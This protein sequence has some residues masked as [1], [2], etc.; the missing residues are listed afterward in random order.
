MIKIKRIS[1]E[2]FYENLSNNA[3]DC[4]HDLNIFKKTNYKYHEIG[5]YYN[6]KNNRTTIYYETGE[7]SKSEGITEN[8]SFLLCWNKKIFG[9]DYVFLVL[10][11]TIDYWPIFIIAFVYGLLF[12][13]D[14]IQSLILEC[15]LAIGLFFFLN[16]YQKLKLL[17]FID[18]ICDI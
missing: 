1:P 9:K 7:K 4:G 14:T 11:D 16:F 6:I 17:N 15:V 12:F 8:K 13:G 2:R 10:I 5:F 18:D 3:I